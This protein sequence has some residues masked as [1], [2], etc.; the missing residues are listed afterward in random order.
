MT[1]EELRAHV[2]ADEESLLKLIERNASWLHDEDEDVAAEWGSR[3]A[4][5][6][7][8]LAT[9][10]MLRKWRDWENS[11]FKNGDV[12]VGVWIAC[13]FT[14]YGYGRTT[15]KKAGKDSKGKIL[16]YTERALVDLRRQLEG[17][18]GRR[19]TSEGEG[20]E[21]V[22]L[23]MSVVSPMFNAGA[24]GV[25]WR[26]TEE[27]IEKVFRGWGGEWLLLAPV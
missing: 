8:P 21:G 17:F 25:P 24:F 7:D 11:G 4:G 26:E 16:G 10:N 1:A 2:F 12:K 5:A 18:G 9:W 14:S 23:R 22:P 6:K 15:K 27:K 3:I 13:L 20:E 19:G